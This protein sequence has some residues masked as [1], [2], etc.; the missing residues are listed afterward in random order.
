L[1]LFSGYIYYVHKGVE[2]S[3]FVIFQKGGGW[4]YS[5]IECA[6][7]AVTG[8]GSNSS[9]FFPEYIDFEAFGET[10]HFNILFS[11]ATISPLTWNWTKIYLPYLDGGSQ[12]GDLDAPVK[13][14]HPNG[15]VST[16]YYRGHRIHHAT[17]ETLLSLE[18]LASA[19]DV[20]L[21]GGSAGGLSTFLHADSWRAAIPTNAKMVAVPDSGFFLNV[22]S[23]NSSGYGKNMRWL[24]NRMNGTNAVPRSCLTAHL[25][26]PALCL[27]AE[28]IS[29]TVKTP[30]FAQQSTY[31]SWQIANILGKQPSDTAAINAYGSLVEKRIFD[32]LIKANTD[33]AVFL[34]SCFHHVG[35]WDLITI[36]GVTVSKALL[37]FYRSVGTPGAKRVWPQGKAY[38]CIACCHNGQ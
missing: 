18:G 29:Q 25:D 20:I 36:D 13:V 14:T 6:N 5:D 9:K 16:I 2:T 30:V 10:S 11:N 34:D 17:V 4:C 8:L 28:V 22:N 15:T 21:S 26:D 3:K 12:I 31:D 32:N 23:T 19:T 7:R 38:P 1:L 37:D 27:F 35:E 24:F 33:H